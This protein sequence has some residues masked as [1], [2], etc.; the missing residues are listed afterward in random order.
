MPTKQDIISVIEAHA[1][2]TSEAIN[3][4]IRSD[5]LQH[6]GILKQIQLQM[7]RILDTC[8]V[9]REY[10]KLR[11]EVIYIYD[12]RDEEFRE[13]SKTEKIK[14]CRKLLQQRG[15]IEKDTQ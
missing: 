2:A 12:T 15:L 4:Q 11:Q 5:D 8:K 9:L 6:D 1:K 10:R 14:I 3:R 7:L 13:S